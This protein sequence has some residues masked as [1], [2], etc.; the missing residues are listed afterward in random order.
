MLWPEVYARSRSLKPMADEFKSKTVYDALAS[1]EAGMNSGEAPLLLPHNQL[2]FATNVTVR[3][4]YATHRPPFSKQVLDFGGDAALE[5]AVT[6]GLFQGSAYYKPDSGVET[7]VASI[8]GHLYQFTPGLTG[9]VVTD[10]S[11]PGDPNSPTQRKSGCSKPR[12][13]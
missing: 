13:G 7:L 11:I 10:I 1:F 8:S 12:N 6:G 9:W 2:S 5:A 4:A 3:G